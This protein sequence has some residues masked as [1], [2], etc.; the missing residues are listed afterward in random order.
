MVAMIAD[1]L[2]V[3]PTI[4]TNTT[5]SVTLQKYVQCSVCGAV[6]LLSNSGS[7]IERCIYSEG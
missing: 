1:T 3:G 2:T 7:I 4:A 6:C 5:G